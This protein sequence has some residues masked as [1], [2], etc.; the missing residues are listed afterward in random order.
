MPR[1]SHYRSKALSLSKVR[2]AIAA[3]DHAKALG[4]PLNLTLD[5]HWQWTRFATE[6]IWNRRKAVT[7]LLE[8]QRHWLS[9]HDVGF[10]CILVREVP[11]SSTEGEH[12]HQ[13]VHVP[14]HLKAAFLRHMR[15]FLR[16]KHRHQRRAL[17]WDTTYSDGKLAYLLK[18]STLPARQ[19]L[20]AMFETDYER[21]HFLEGTKN[22]I[23]QGVIY[24]KRL[25]VS[26]ALG[27]KARRGA[28]CGSNDNRNK[29]PEVS[30]IRQHINDGGARRVC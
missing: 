26:Q 14:D 21:Q 22:K 11:P 30:R 3:H 27:P 28:T 19:L 18:G 20:A 29:P 2:E 1:S 17:H 16:G 25:F 24:G 23:H 7:A 10:L 8:S 15:K 6:G 4:C 13:L 9:N 5:I 12:A